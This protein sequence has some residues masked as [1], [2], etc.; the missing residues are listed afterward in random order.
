MHSEH[1]DALFIGGPSTMTGCLLYQ[2]RYPEHKVRH[3]F[4]DRFD[5]NYDGSAYYYHQRDAAPVYINR[6]NRGPYCVYIDLRKRLMKPTTLAY[7]A[8][9]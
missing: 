8:E 9:N 3:A 4:A 5:S 6:V 2:L 7:Q 1:L